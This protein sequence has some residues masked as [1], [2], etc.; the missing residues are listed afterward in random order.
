MTRKLSS[1]DRLQRKL[2]RELVWF[3]Y[4]HG[5][6]S[7]HWGYNEIREARSKSPTGYCIDWLKKED[8]IFS[9]WPPRWLRFV[10]KVPRAELRYMHPDSVWKL[11]LR[12]MEEA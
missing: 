11:V 5:F 12:G 2:K 6:E 1:A 4:Q 9:Y 3:V 10:R 8:G 7:L